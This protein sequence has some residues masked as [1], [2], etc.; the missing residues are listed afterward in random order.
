MAGHQPEFRAALTRR[1]LLVKVSLTAALVMS[2]CQS[3]Q[4]LEV[5]QSGAPKFERFRA[6]YR[7]D[8]ADQLLG[9]SF[10][11]VS[12]GSETPAVQR[13]AAESFMSEARLKIECPHPAG[14]PS[15]ALLTLTLSDRRG[16]GALLHKEARQLTIERSNVELLI[17]SLANNGYFDQPSDI[18]GGNELA[19]QIDH[20][21]INREWINDAR[22]LD[23]A[24][25]ALV[26]G[27]PVR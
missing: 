18:V 19:V 7:F 6:E 8:N 20:G 17:S 21:K 24:R 1:R 13:V 16:P 9:R 2:G 22:L 5:T 26:D 27:K 11:D 10:A 14:D 15:L 3:A 23:L 25:Q 12:S 4:K